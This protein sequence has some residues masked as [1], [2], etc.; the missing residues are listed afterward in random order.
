MVRQAESD[1]DNAI[2]VKI[3]LMGGEVSLVALTA[4]AT[5]EEALEAAGV[6]TDRNVKCNGE[7]VNLSDIVEDGDRLI[8]TDNVKGGAL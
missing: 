2:E 8:I 4:E 7:S 1:G 5:V 3:A 6:D